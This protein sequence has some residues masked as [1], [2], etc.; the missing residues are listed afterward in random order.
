MN[1]EKEIEKIK[2]GILEIPKL[3]WNKKMSGRVQI[4]VRYI[5]SYL[6]LAVKSQDGG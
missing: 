3:L 2:V 6:K 1:T 5:S 4:P